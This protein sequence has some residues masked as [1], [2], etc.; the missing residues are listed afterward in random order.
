MSFFTIRVNFV[1]KMR[2]KKRKEKKTGINSYQNDL[3]GNNISS[4]YHV[5]T[6]MQ[7]TA[8]YF[9]R[10][11]FSSY[12]DIVWAFLPSARPSVRLYLSG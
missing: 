12:L 11:H 2:L 7:K 9:F 3:Y 8:P 6:R 4:R 1:N 10:S 5:N